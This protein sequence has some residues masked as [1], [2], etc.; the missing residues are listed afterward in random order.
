[1]EQFHGQNN[2]FLVIDALFN[3]AGMEVMS[4]A[5]YMTLSNF[6]RFQLK[7]GIFRIKVRYQNIKIINFLDDE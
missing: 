4:K 2:D 3:E 5:S 1:M 6:K 7:S